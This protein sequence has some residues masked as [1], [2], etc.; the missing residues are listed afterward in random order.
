MYKIVINHTHKSLL[1]SEYNLPNFVVLTGINGSGKTQ[2][3]EALNNNQLT[4]IYENDKKLWTRTLIPLNSLS[5]IDSEHGESRNQGMKNHASILWDAYNHA[6]NPSPGI[7]SKPNPLPSFEEKLGSRN[8][9]KVR[10]I[11][12]HAEKDIENLELNDFKEH[13]PLNDA[14][15][16]DDFFTQKFSLIFRNYFDKQRENQ[17]KMFRKEWLKIT[18]VTYLTN[19]E[20]VDKYGNP[21][22]VINDLIEAAKLEYEFNEPTEAN[23]ETPFVLRLINKRTKSEIGLNDLSSGEK[24]IMSLVFALYNSKLEFQFPQVL[25]LDEPDASLHPSMA[26]QFLDVIEDVFVKER[27]VKVIMTTHS[28]STVA[29][30]PEKSLFV[31]NKTT[32]RIRKTTKDEALSILT[33]GVPSLSVNYE[34]RRQVFVESEYDVF[35]YDKL[36]GKLKNK[37]IPEISLNFISSGIGN[38]GN[39]D[40]V[41]DVVNKLAIEFKNKYIFGIIDWDGKNGGNKHVKIL[42]KGKRYSIEN[43]ILDPILIAAFLLRETFITREDLN[44]SDNETYVDFKNLSIVRLQ[45]ISDFVTDRIKPLINP[46]DDIKISIMNPIIRTGS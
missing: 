30:A 26:K 23:L 38:S 8:L 29:L 24:V 22:K 31:I 17:E 15:I 20:F 3:L 43:Y 27:G 37:L 2:F 10:A 21:R 46:T 41:R 5:P 13:I 32:P 33:Q 16:N 25:L 42:G 36:Y 39:C 28:A 9:Q 34:N 44:L 35:F 1:P 14:N 18:N 40:Q 4:D 11:A 12:R 6:K 19:E 45:A 7:A